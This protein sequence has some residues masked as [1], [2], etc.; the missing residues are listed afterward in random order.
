M[1]PLYT[2]EPNKGMEEEPLSTLL[3]P[4]PPSALLL[5]GKGATE[6]TEVFPEPSPPIHWK[7]DKRYTTVMGPC[8]SSIVRGLLGLPGDVRSTRQSGT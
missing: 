5:L 3:P 7:K 8:L 6:E 4:L 2:E 1:A